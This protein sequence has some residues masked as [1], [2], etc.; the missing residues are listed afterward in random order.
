MPDGMPGRP[1]ASAIGHP[2]ERISKFL[3]P[4]LRP[5]MEN[6]PSYLKDTSDYIYETPSF[7]FHDQT[8]LVTMD[9]TSLYTNFPQQEGISLGYETYSE[10][11]TSKTVRTRRMKWVESR[12]DLNNFIELANGLYASI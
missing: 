8:L 2:T 7:G 6:L 10:T 11:I 3:D 5:H 1:I 9:V 4:H 12:R